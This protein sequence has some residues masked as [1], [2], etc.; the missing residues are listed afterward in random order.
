MDFSQ[1]EPGSLLEKLFNAATN[2]LALR[3]D[4]QSVLGTFCEKSMK[5]SFEMK[6]YVF[7]VTSVGPKTTDRCCP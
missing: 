7:L 1:N 4:N 2:L 6:L 5:L 3:E